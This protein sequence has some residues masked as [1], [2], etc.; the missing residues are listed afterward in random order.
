MIRTIAIC[1][2]SYSHPSKRFSDSDRSLFTPDSR[3]QVNA[4]YVVKIHQNGGSLQ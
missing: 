1:V 3:R 4:I 2:F